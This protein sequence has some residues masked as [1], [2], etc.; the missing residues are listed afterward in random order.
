MQDLQEELELLGIIYETA[1]DPAVWPVIIDVLSDMLEQP[2][3]VHVLPIHKK[4][5]SVEPVQNHGKR[6]TSLE[7]SRLHRLSGYFSRAIDIKKQYRQLEDSLHAVSN[8]VDKLPVAI[9]LFDTEGNI[10]LSNHKAN[11]ILRESHFISLRNGMFCCKDGHAQTQIR[12]YFS[13]IAHIDSTEQNEN[14][15]IETIRFDNNTAPEMMS[16]LLFPFSHNTLQPQLKNHVALIISGAL[17]GDSIHEKTIQDLFGV[18]PAE[19]S[20]M[21]QLSL[22]RTAD[23]IADEKHVSI[24]TIK[25]Q[26]KSIFLKT[27]TSKQQ[28][29]IKLVVTSPAIYNDRNHRPTSIHHTD[30]IC[31][32]NKEE[33]IS[34]SDGRLL[35]YAEFGDKDGIPLLYLHSALGCR[36]EISPNRSS[37]TKLGIRLIVPERPGIGKSSPLIGRSVLDWVDDCSELLDHLRLPTTNVLG[38]SVGANYA[39][40]LAYKIPHRLSRVTIVSPSLPFNNNEYLNQLTPNYRLF[41]A[42]GRYLP[43]MALRLFERMIRK[44]NANPDKFFDKVISGE[45]ND[46]VSQIPELRSMRIQCI[47][48]IGYHGIHSCPWEMLLL[49]K[50]LGFSYND[51]N[52]PISIWQGTND[53]ESPYYRVKKMLSA[54]NYHLHTL[55]DEGHQILF[56]FWHGILKTTTHSSLSS[57]EFAGMV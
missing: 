56:K 13:K 42:L 27:G 14:D 30:H 46:Y 12:N 43:S 41:V 31:V 45:R 10:V 39:L 25:S 28:E 15:L 23:Q 22:G 3:N 38:Y 55:H 19:A 48:E 29:V 53:Q 26:L 17:P 2:D 5:T 40:A 20:L 6:T 21:K 52:H 7:S 18:T 11:D 16:G 47:K 57:P 54:P 50:P 24:N 51:I 1:V 8:I 33:V 35:S 4:Y 37:L 36:F 49:V 34:L 44:A 32:P 9:I